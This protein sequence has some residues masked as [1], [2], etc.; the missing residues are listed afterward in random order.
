MKTK[1]M[2]AVVALLLAHMAPVAAQHDMSCWVKVVDSKFESRLIPWYTY[3][4]DRVY[5]DAR[6][7]FDWPN[8]AGAFAGPAYTVGKWY[9]APVAGLILGD[10]DAL[11]AELN[12]VYANGR[13]ACVGLDQVAV[14]K[15][16]VGLFLYH[17]RDFTHRTFSYAKLGAGEQVY[18]D[19]SNFFSVDAGPE[20][21]FLWADTYLKVWPAV[22]Y[23]RV[24]GSS[25]TRKKIFL[26]LGTGFTK[27]P[28]F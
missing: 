23:I 28:M 8:S 16:D 10:Y 4:T 17:W 3:A 6:Y 20:V 2:F 25:E 27:I 14:S 7:N 9:V 5:L 19:S 24:G 18:W 26:G 15:D 21:K 22:N 12:T 13:F 11:T 1:H